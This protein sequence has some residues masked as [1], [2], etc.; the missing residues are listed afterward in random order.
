MKK[1][2]AIALLVIG[3]Y[4]AVRLTRQPQVAVATLVGPTMGT[5][6]RVRLAGDL[7]ASEQETWQRRIQACVDRVNRRM[8][9]Y[10]GDSEISRFNQSRSQEWFSV[11]RDT[12]TVVAASLDVSRQTDGAFDI[13]IGPL[14]NI[15]DLVRRNALEACLRMPKLEQLLRALGTGTWRCGSTPPPCGRRSPTSTLTC[16]EL[17]KDLRWTRLRNCSSKGGS[18]RI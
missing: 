15:W 10:Q 4:L 3:A 9:T 17:Q 6:Y 12:A 18:R 11:S 7:S 5:T 2:V 8:S 13:T 16:R 1:I 14:V